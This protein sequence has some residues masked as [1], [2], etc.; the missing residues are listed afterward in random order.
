KIV[1]RR[2]NEYICFVELAIVAELQDVVL[3]ASGQR[4]NVLRRNAHGVRARIKRFN[5]AD[6]LTL[7]R[8]VVDVENPLLPLDAVAGWAGEALDEVRAV[9]VRRFKDDDVTALGLVEEDASRDKWKA[10]RQ[11]MLAVAVGELLNEEEV[12]D[13]ERVFHRAGGNVERL[14]QEGAENE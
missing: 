1:A 2:N 5:L 12:A 9:V 3:Y 4:L 8:L 10:E 14:E 11:R 7:H 6:A 13:E